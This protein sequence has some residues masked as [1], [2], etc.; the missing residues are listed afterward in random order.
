MRVTKS[1]RTTGVTT[2]VITATHVNGV[3][4]NYGTQTHPRIAIFN[5]TIEIV[6]DGGVPFSNPGDSGSLILDRASGRPVALLFAGDG[7][8]TTACDIGG[9]CQEFQALPV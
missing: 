9:V 6:G 2:G 5:D 7:R 4:I 3:H 1:G 8:T